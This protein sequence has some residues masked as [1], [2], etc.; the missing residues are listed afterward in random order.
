MNLLIFGATGSIGS[1][2]L[3]VVKILPVL[4]CGLIAGVFFAFSTF[5]MKAL[6]KRPPAE[7]IGAMQSINIVVINPWFMSV[8]VGTAAIC[9]LLAI[10]SLW[11]WQQPVSIYLIIG[12]LLYIVGSFGVTMAFNVPLNDALAIAKPDSPEAATL[13]ARYL[14]DWT[15]W[16][17]VRTIASLAAAALFAIAIGK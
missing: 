9:L 16:N 2:S 7:G 14:V 11:Q 5:V 10:Y 13:W 12:S 1:Q 6:G 15:F 17:T 3:F 4:G 8:F